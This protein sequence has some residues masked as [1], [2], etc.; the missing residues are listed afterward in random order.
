M[1]CVVLHLRM[2]LFLPPNIKDLDYHKTIEFKEIYFLFTITIFSPHSLLP[3]GF[4]WIKKIPKINTVKCYNSNRGYCF[5]H[6][7]LNVKVHLYINSQQ[8]WIMGA[9]FMGVN[10]YTKIIY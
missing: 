7:S 8:I 10:D 4:F 9:C 2:Y 6:C 3:V 5:L 1:P